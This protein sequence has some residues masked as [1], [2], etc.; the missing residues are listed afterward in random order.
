MIYHSNVALLVFI[1]IDLLQ[2][3]NAT[4]WEASMDT[5]T[6]QKLKFVPAN[7]EYL[8]IDVKLRKK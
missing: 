5:S 4:K 1:Y 6:T 8:V 7:L 3:T 2:I